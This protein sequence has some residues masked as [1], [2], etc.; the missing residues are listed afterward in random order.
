VAR[1]KVM[2]DDNYHFMDEDERYELGVFDSA[3]AAIAA[4]RRIV[5]EWLQHG[6]KPGMS[7]DQLYEGYVGFGEDPFIVPLE[8]APQVKF[9]AW[10]YARE[11][12]VVIC[13]ATG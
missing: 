1:Y 13:A 6:Y 2:V 12:S 7:A 11:R 10:D 8:D 9:S 4:C 3:E 5:D